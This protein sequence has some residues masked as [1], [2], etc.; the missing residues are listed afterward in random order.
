MS[1]YEQI[2]GT[3]NLAMKRG[4]DFS[5]LVDFSLNMTGYTT[6]ASIVSAVSGDTVTPFT[7]TV[8]SAAN[9][10]VNISLNDTQTAALAAGT[11]RWQMAW[12]Q[13]NATRTAL[14]GFVEVS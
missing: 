14:T 11:Y 2:P 5:A 9:G 10:Q 3:L 12:V 6:T 8:Q 13:G 1:V 7:V 4:D